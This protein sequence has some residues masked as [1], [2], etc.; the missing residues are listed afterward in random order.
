[1]ACKIVG[2][3]SSRNLERSDHFATEVAQAAPG[4][5]HCNLGLMLIKV[6]GLQNEQQQHIVLY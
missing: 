2:P 1:V 4:Y 6:R 3:L 5:Q